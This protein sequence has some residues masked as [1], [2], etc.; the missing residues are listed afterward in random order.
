MNP[1]MTAKLEKYMM[2]TGYYDTAAIRRDEGM[3]N[4]A[5][6]FFAI[7]G[8][9][10]D[11][12]ETDKSELL[13]AAE[14]HNEDQYQADKA[15]ETPAI[16][17]TVYVE[18]PDSDDDLL[19]VT[20]TETTEQPETAPE[21]DPTHVE[22]PI[23][24][25][26]F[27]KSPDGKDKRVYANTRSGDEGVLYITGNHWHERNSR[28]GLT[29]DLWKLVARLCEEHAGKKVWCSVPEADCAILVPIEWL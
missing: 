15:D 25:I 5:S 9:D 22:N 23:K 14:A 17:K 16:T 12:K 4:Q 13:L 27:W 18:W 1:E 11:Q 2:E 28:D 7:F 8:D 19:M 3:S 21:V 24:N 20:I 6:A 29:P 10:N 26:R